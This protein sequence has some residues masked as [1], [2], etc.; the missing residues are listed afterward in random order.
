MKCG[1]YRYVDDP[2]F[3]IM[4]F[5]YAFDDDKAVV[6]DL[7]RGGEVPDKVIKALTDPTITKKAHNAS[8]ERTC[9]QEWTGNPMPPEEWKCSAIRAR[10]LG[11]PGS[12]EAVGNALGFAEEDKKSKTGKA[13]IRYFC[14]PCKAT[15]S[16][17]GRTRNLPSMPPTNGLHL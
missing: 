13:L 2:S 17:G 14:M 5:G 16:N 7:M 15:K 9:L 8:F 1:V 4:L 10:Q 12:L 3:E 6:V 11:L